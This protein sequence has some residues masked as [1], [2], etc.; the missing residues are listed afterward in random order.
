MTAP[1][2]VM[3]LAYDPTL[4]LGLVFFNT[5]AWPAALFFALY[6]A[7]HAA[8]DA[9]SELRSTSSEMLL[10]SRVTLRQWFL[11]RLISAVMHDVL[12]LLSILPFMLCTV[13]HGGIDVD[14]VL[15]TLFV[16]LAMIVM[17]VCNGL[18]LA[19]RPELRQRFHWRDAMSV[20]FSLPWA[21]VGISGSLGAV[22][23]CVWHWVVCLLGGCATIFFIG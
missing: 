19:D 4:P 6:P 2:V 16:M 8:S 22:P 15:M 21:L 7:W 10:L 12:V 3:H 1:L 20:L 17:G 11:G 18:S 9:W 23:I 5:L 13:Q 14:Q